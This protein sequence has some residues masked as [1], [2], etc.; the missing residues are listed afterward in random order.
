MKLISN[1]MLAF[2]I[3]LSAVS[4]AHA[5][6]QTPAEMR[7][8]AAKLYAQADELTEKAVK[9]EAEQASE[10]K[11]RGNEVKL[12]GYGSSSCVS[13]CIMYTD[14]NLYSCRRACGSY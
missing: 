5:K 2:V 6:D 7:A 3:A 13:D 8:E 12:R 4:I 14:T 10:V 11:S 9:M 1:I